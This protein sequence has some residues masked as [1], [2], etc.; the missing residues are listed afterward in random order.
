MASRR[1]YA[2]SH[3]S[4][5]ADKLL[6]PSGDSVNGSDSSLESREENLKRALEAALG[7]LGALGGIYEQREARWKE[8][9][10]RVSEERERVELL[11][12][13]TLGVG[14]TNGSLVGRAL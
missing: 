4:S 5:L 12:Q 8:E 14:L 6:L 11:L 7:S 9:M 2:R 10:H 3:K 1:R 13:Q